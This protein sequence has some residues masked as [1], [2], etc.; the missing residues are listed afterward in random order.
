MSSPRERE[1]GGA[2]RVITVHTKVTEYRDQT[3]AYEI[4]S[5]VEPS[6]E[7][8]RPKIT[9]DLPGGG[10]TEVPEPSHRAIARPSRSVK[11]AKRSKSKSSVPGNTRRCFNCNAPGHVRAYC[12]SPPITCYK[13]GLEGHRFIFCDMVAEKL[14]DRAVT[15]IPKG[16]EDA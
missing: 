14:G 12:R 4:S 11:R 9:R 2:V 10:G 1:H 3:V 6:S 7:S 16:H 5:S 15:S 13:C 8:K